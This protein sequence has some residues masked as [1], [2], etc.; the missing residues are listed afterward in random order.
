[1]GITK[2][3]VGVEGEKDTKN[4]KAGVKRR[5]DQTRR[6]QDRERIKKR[7]GNGGE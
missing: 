4:V 5:T 1:M 7:D 6:M 3:V 2:G